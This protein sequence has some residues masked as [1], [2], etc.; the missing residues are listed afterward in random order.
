MFGG[1]IVAIVSPMQENG[2]IDE[3][4]FRNLIKWHLA[5]GTNGIVVNGT[6]GEAA[7]LTIAE[8][9]RLIEIALQSCAGKIP[10]IAG[11][12]S[13]STTTTI[14]MTKIAMNL[15]V[16]GCLIVTPYYNKP[17]QTG[18]YE[19]FKAVATSCNVP[20]ILY[21]VPSR[22]GCDLL[23]VTV[24][25]LSKLSNIVGIKEATGDVTRVKILRDSCRPGFVILSG[26]DGI[27]VKFIQAGGNGVISVAANVVPKR[28]AKL[29]KLAMTNA[30][31]EA[32]NLDSTLRDL[33]KILFIESNPIPVKWALKQLG[34][35]K[36]GIRLPLTKLTLENRGNLQQILRQ[37]YNLKLSTVASSG[38]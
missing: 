23:P 32:E 15:G 9:T 7:T 29:C 2:E 5:Q 6:T 1:S 26:D 36:E 35:I 30:L 37:I 20:I 17:T 34:F 4:S 8:R 28:M 12:G 27:V 25:S 18:L 24:A 38:L 3:V 33:Y 14:E 16:S 11:T 21:N 13:N 19:H 10:V 22:T 31:M